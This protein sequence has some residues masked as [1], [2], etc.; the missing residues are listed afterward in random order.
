MSDKI[1]YPYIPNSVPEIK[2]E[3]MEFVGVKD[4]MELYEEIPENLKYDGLLN[5]PPAILDE[6]SMKRHIDGILAKNK[7]V[8]EYSSF[9]GSGYACHYAPAV[10][11]EIGS[12]GEFVTSYGGDVYGDHGKYQVWFEA[13]TMICMLTGMEFQAQT[14]HDGAQ[15]ASTAICMANRINGRKRVLV[16]ESMNPQVLSV[17]KNYTNSV[18]PETKLIIEKVKY[19]ST[20]GTMDMADLKSKLDDSVSAVFIENPTYL[21][22][23][24]DKAVEIGKLAAEA[25]AEYIVYADPISLGA[26]EAPRNYGATIC[27]GDLHSLGLHLNAGGALAG[28]INTPDE[29][30]YMQETKELCSGLVDTVVEGELGFAQNLYQ[31]TH[32]AVREKGKEFT[33]TQSNLW[34][35]NVA[36][37]LSLMGPDGMEEV[38]DTIMTNALYGAREIA[39][40][41]RV[42]LRFTAPFFKEFVVDFNETGKTVDEINKALLEKKIFGGASLK[43]D[44]P[45]LGESALYCITEV[46]TKEQIDQLA[47]ALREVLE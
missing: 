20:T 21:G 31:R 19:D 27:V 23:M 40:I 34:L 4:E 41:P 10:C 1:M 9:L 8:D 42:S 7:G 47:N 39:Q 44:F 11:D 45:E 29:M 25:G 32:Y 35:V 36:T 14:C 33:G 17:V 26:M 37:Y 28:F 16:P 13:Q 18:N 5:L 38:A 3:M 6:Y 24:E 15:A 2:K 46:N 43:C 22:I 30:K 12:R